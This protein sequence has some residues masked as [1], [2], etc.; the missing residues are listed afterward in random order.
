M[1]VAAREATTQL[2]GDYGGAVAALDGE[3]CED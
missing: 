3:A 2:L 1:R